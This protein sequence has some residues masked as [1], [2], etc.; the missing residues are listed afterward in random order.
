MHAHA[1]AYVHVAAYIGA[2]TSD[3]N[4]YNIYTCDIYIFVSLMW[5]CTGGLVN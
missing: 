5:V 1:G 3:T 4:R 2:H